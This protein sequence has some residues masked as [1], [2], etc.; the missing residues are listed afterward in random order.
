MSSSDRKLSAALLRNPRHHFVHSRKKALEQGRHV[1][2]V[3][4]DDQVDRRNVAMQRTSDSGRRQQIL[5]IKP[6]QGEKPRARGRKKSFWNFAE[7]CARYP[8]DLNRFA[9]RAPARW[10]RASI[11]MD[12]APILSHRANPRGWNFRERH[13]PLRRDDWVQ[14]GA[15][16]PAPQAPDR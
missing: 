14:P 16:G 11:I 15:A 9:T 10:S 12:D 7:M 5:G 8:R 4:A 6:Q 1:R 13:R 2:L 3:V